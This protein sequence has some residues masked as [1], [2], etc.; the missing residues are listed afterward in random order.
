M[1]SSAPRDR[2]VRNSGR[3]IEMRRPRAA[4]GR[5]SPLYLPTGRCGAGGAGAHSEGGP[6][7]KPR[8]TRGGS[9]SVRAIG[10]PARQRRPSAFT[11]RSTL[12][13]ARFP[14][15]QIARLCTFLVKFSGW[16][17]RPGALALTEG[18][19]QPASRR[20]Y[21]PPR[22]RRRLQ[23]SDGNAQMSWAQELSP[24]GPR[25]PASR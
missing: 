3:H 14:G 2:F 25:T 19:A 15:T 16:K 18:D 12:H 6:E 5:V 22:D 4:A 9:Q 20:P 21:P 7:R 24:L 1:V 10:R 11:N 17:L 8:P 23:I 13:A